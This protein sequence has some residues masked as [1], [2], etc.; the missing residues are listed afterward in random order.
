[1]SEEE[2]FKVVDRRRFSDS[3]ESKSD[4]A[5]QSSREETSSSLN[6]SP[7][8]EDFS[9]ELGQDSS[10]DFPS[11]V[12]GLATQTMMMLG[13]IPNPETNLPQVNLEAAKQTIDILGLLEEKTKGNLSKDEDRLLQDLL[14]NLRLAYVSKIRGQ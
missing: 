7:E 6:D 10:V 11:F 14:A 8:F 5:E 4:N 13:E 1:M 2:G 12:M 3:G 9:E